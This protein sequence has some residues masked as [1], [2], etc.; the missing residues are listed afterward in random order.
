MTLTAC[1]PKAEEKKPAGPPPTIITT[2]KISAHALDVTENTL[3]TL[4]SL[5][6]PKIGAEVP[7]RVIQV[8]THA[9]QRVRKGDTMALIDPSDLALAVRSDS[10]ELQRLKS[11]LEQQERLVKR[12]KDLVGKGFV[13]QN[14]VDDAVAQRDA[15]RAQLAAAQVRAES[16]RSNEGK[17]RVVAPI[18]GE[19]ETQ[20]VATGDYVKVGDPVFKMVSNRRLRAI[21]PYPEAAAARIRR[22]QPVRI[23]SPQTPGLVVNGKVEDIRPVISAGSRSIDVIVRFDNETGLLAGGT[24]NGSV[25]IDRRDG[26][27]LVPEQSVVLRPAGTVVYAV[28]DGKASQR[29]VSTGTRSGGMVEITQGLRGGET[30][31]LDGAGFLSDGAAVSIKED[32]RK[33]TANKDVANPKAARQA[34]AQQP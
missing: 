6:D 12:Q 5:I 33:E 11:L 8:L 25:L 32:A 18:D 31:A 7:G 30:V 29:I 21:L 23:T 28:A 34:T 9:G 10:A 17:A 24:I 20:I 27:V 2:T 19:V 22:G 14:A 26:A 4:E 15:L 16:G 13:S 1:A 3:G